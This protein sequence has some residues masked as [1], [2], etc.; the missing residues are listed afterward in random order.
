MN[1]EE[2]E[3]NSEGGLYYNGKYHKIK[4]KIVEV[5]NLGGS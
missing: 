5:K 4:I 3:N 2:I 1:A